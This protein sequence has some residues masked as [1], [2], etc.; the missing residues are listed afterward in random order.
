MTVPSEIGLAPDD[1]ADDGEEVTVFDDDAVSNGVVV[2]TITEPDTIAGTDADG[3]LAVFVL[4]SR[5][6]SAELIAF[7]AV[8]P[9]LTPGIS[10]GIG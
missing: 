7:V 2:T 1:A 4:M 10:T 5:V 8:V 3:I 6:L 9:P